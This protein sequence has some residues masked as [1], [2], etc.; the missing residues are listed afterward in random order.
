MTPY[1]PQLFFTILALTCAI[2]LVVIPLACRWARIVRFVDKPGGRK[3]HGRPIPPIGGLII[4]PV[5]M[6]GLCAAGFNPISHW[7]LYAA[8]CTLLAV[9]AVDDLFHIPPWPKFAAQFIAAYLVTVP[10]GAELQHLGNLFGHGAF[11]LGFMSMPFTIIAV[12]LLINAINL[13]DGLDGLA[14]GKAFI[15]LF[16]FMLAAALS[17]QFAAA[18]VVAPALGVIAGFL[19]YNMRHPL[20]KRAS[21]FLGDAGSMGLGLIIAWY[22]IAFVQGPDP[23]MVPISVAWVLALPIIDS[24]GQF[25][26]RVLEGRHP[27]SPDRGHFHHHVLAAGLSVGESTMLILGIGFLFGL[28]GYGGIWLGV[29]VWMLTYGWIA[30]LFTHMALSKRPQV[31]IDF[32]KTLFGR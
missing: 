16:W 30:L 18:I 1:S 21:I 23:V 6:V 27:F 10:G 19:F 2:V 32:L 12:V 20:R 22:S 17:G 14:G 26:R 25:F 7:P 9:G 24:C 11:S 28:I 3:E 4:F 8:L 31:Y 5:F 13:M 29:P 15:M